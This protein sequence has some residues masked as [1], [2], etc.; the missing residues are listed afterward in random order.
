MDDITR[1]L[2]EDLQH[3]GDIT[4]DTFFT[5]E[6]AEATIIAKQDC[7]LAGVEESRNVFSHTG[8]TYHAHEQDG[9]AL[10]K[11]TSVATINGPIRSILS[12]ERLAL[13]ILGRMSGI[14]TQTRNIVDLCKPLNH[15]IEIAATR[16]TTPGFRAYEKKAVVIGG[17]VAHRMGLYDAILIKDNHLKFIGSIEQAIG[18]TRNKHESCPIEIEVENEH[19]ALIAAQHS[20]EVIMLDNFPP[21]KA[22]TTAEKIRKID[23]SIHIEISGGITKKNIRRYASFAD[24]ISLGILTHT[25]KNIDFSLELI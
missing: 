10:K 8:A 16:K 1:F 23:S 24:R 12:G 15:S 21:E 9:E 6:K 18:I 11:Q 4:S 22:K 13:N 20:V 17:G 7:I 2:N 3:Q 19:D 5:T 25:I 14:A